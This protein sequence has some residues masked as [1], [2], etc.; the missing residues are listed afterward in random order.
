MAVVNIVRA[1]RRDIVANN[2]LSLVNDRHSIGGTG[3]RRDGCHLLPVASQ[4]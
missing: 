1:G 2:V 4:T 3:D